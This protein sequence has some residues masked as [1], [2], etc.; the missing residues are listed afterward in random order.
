MSDDHQ[1]TNTHDDESDIASFSS[2]DSQEP[3]FH[4]ATGKILPAR[5]AW[6]L[7]AA[8]GHSRFIS[9]LSG[10]SNTSKGKGRGG[11]SN[12]SSGVGGGASKSVFRNRLNTGDSTSSG[13]GGTS[14]V[15]GVVKDGDGGSSVV[16]I[17]T[18]NAEPQSTTTTATA[19]TPSIQPSLT[20]DSQISSTSEIQHTQIT[21]SSIDRALHPNLGT[22]PNPLSPKNVTSPG[23]AGDSD[24]EETD[25]IILR[26]KAMALAAQNGQQLTPEQLLLIAQPDVQQQKLIEET[27]KAKELQLQQHQQQQSFI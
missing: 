18:S 12:S 7:L 27:R 22:T 4:V 20:E 5:E 15:S 3:Y 16:S 26:A 23:G 21:Q 14:I 19:P 9:K 25:P 17:S 8:E 10:V 13:G 24:D 2:E 1:F 11:R 6:H